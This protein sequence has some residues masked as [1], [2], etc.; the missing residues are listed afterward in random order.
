MAQILI[1]HTKMTTA[2]ILVIFM[3]LGGILELAGVYQFLV[4][5]GGA[6]ATVPISGFGSLLVKGTIEAVE[7]GGWFSALTGGMSAVAAG[8]TA[9]I[10]VSF[11]IALIAK[12]KT[13]G[14]KIKKS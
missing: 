1:N 10:S 11:L 3:L 5:I 7:K 9:V 8:L 2:R 6:G 14:V 4:K 12:A 13:K